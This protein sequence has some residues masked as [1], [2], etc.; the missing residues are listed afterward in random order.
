[1]SPSM[2]SFYVF[3]LSC[4]IGYFVC[5]RLFSLEAALG[6]LVIG[7]L[8]F[9]AYWKPVYLV[10][11]LF[12]IGFNFTIGSVLS[13]DDNR[14]RRSFLVF[15]IV[16]NLSLIAY[17]KYAN[18]FV[19]NVNVILGTRWDIGNIFLPLAIS[20]FTFQQIS[21]LVDAWRGKTSEYNFLHFFPAHFFL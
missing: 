14:G 9:Y 8:F 10:L 12:S 16:V 4:V 5:A 21:Y 2:T 17:F 19:D 20:F 1:M 11:L 13:R 6:F 18:F 3:V 7:S 15:G